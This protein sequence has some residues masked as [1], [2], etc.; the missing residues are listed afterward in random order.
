MPHEIVQSIAPLVAMLMAGTFGLIGFRMWL[1]H[2]PLRKG[3]LG[4]E[5]LD[6]LTDTVEDIRQQVELMRDE[7]LELHER[8]DFAERLLAQHERRDPQLEKPHHTPV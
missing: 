5:Q 3:K 2:R 7:N 4:A 8:V 6:R 1:A